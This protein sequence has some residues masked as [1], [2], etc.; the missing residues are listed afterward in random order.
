MGRDEPPPL[1]FESWVA[2]VEAELSGDPLW[3]MSA[4]RLAA[5]LGYA[6]WWDARA[7]DSRALT[8]PVAGQL[9]RSVNSIGANIA[10]GYGKSSGRDRVR[11]FEY[12][13]GSAR[14]ARHWYLAA[15]PVLGP[16]AAQDRTRLLSRI[17]KI[18]LVAIPA[19]RTRQL[20]VAR[21][22]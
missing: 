13:L 19:E 14:E 8:S 11:F 2:R 15:V 3:R 7:L 5:Y 18:L 6:S 10:E 16:A 17:I 21:V 4:Y 9:Y 22:T 1:G 20:H 12:A